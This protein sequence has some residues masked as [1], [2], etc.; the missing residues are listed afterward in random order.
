MLSFLASV[1]VHRLQCVSTVPHPPSIH[2]GL[3]NLP[4]DT[5]ATC[6]AS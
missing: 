4:S 3:L 6:A 5:S 1:H 2:E